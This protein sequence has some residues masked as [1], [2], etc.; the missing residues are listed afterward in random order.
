MASCSVIYGDIFAR[1]DLP[2]HPENQDRL[3][4]ALT[5][6]P[7]TIPR[8]VPKSA[9]PQD[10]TRIH[11][12]GY[13]RW[14]EETCRTIRQIR[15]IDA[16][17]Y[18]TPDTYMVTL[19]ASGAAIEAAERSLDGEGCF[20]LIRPPGHHAERNMAMGFCIFNHAAIAA[21]RML[22][23]VDRVAILDWDEHHG[24]GTQHAFYSSSR[25]LY[26]SV[27]G[28]N[29]FPGTGMVEET[30]V[31]EGRGFTVNAP[32][33][34]DCTRSDYFLVFAR[35][36]VPALIRFRPEACIISAGQDML[37]DDPLSTMQLHPNDVGMLTR[38][39]TEV[40]EVPPALVLEGGYGPSHGKAIESIFRAVLGKGIPSEDDRVIQ[41]RE[42]TI[43]TVDRLCELHH[44]E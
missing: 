36:F 9:I 23:R 44:L 5:G 10:I 1:H 33:E 25:V 32:L 27:H 28:R 40:L 3:L 24:N 2:S 31:S 34:S 43:R 15:M 12:P 35:V 18:L 41:P 13:V 26:C 8:T 30:G 6:V 37:A 19:A 22:D 4:N 39:I 11:D 14:I 21:S 17:T 7:P 16:D 20:A 29:M 42:S 38:M